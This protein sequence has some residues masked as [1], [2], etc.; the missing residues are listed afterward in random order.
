MT[1]RKVCLGLLLVSAFASA[2]EDPHKLLLSLKYHRGEQVIKEVNFYGTEIDPNT[3]TD[4]YGQF[5][6][7]VDGRE[8]GDLSSAT[9]W[10]LHRVRRYFSY[11]NFSQG[12]RELEPRPITCKLAGPAVGITLEA[13]YLTY[14]NHQIA[15][16]ELRVVY[17]WPSNCLYQPK[18]QP[19][20][21]IAR[22]SARGVMETLRTIDELSQN[23]R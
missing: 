1:L 12:I 11:D 7:T 22:E 16:D 4:E 14:E 2:S 15:D 6:V 17:D 13:R 23:I 20:S 3:T 18:Y 10:R 8:I 19:V 5:K 9:F 21:A